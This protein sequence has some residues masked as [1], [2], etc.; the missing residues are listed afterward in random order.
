MS[1]EYC[2]S[3]TSDYQRELKAFDCSQKIVVPRKSGLAASEL[4]GSDADVYDTL[5][6]GHVFAHHLESAPIARSTIAT[7]NFLI[8]ARYY[9]FIFSLHS[10][11]SHHSPPKSIAKQ[12]FIVPH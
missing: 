7:R 5:F 1:S 2:D 10:H 11:F 9:V 8:L 3:E 12:A 6:T 4:L